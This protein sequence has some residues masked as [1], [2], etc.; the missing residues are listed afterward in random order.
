MPKEAKVSRS[1]LEAGRMTLLRVSATGKRGVSGIVS[2]ISRRCPLVVVQKCRLSNGRGFLFPET[3]FDFQPPVILRRGIGTA[4][5]HC[6]KKEVQ[7]CCSRNNKEGRGG[8]GQ[9]FA[10]L[11]YA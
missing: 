9:V 6:E 10:Y 3:A 2:A 11:S 7:V 5:W 8:A 4:G 1:T